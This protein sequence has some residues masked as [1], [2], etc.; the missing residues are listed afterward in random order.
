MLKTLRSSKGFTL[1]EL[2]V[3]LVIIGILAT[4]VVFMYTDPVAKVK[5]AAFN[6]RG[7]LNFAR[8]EAVARNE[9]VLVDFLFD[10]SDECQGDI[11]K[12]GVAGDSDG[13]IICVDLDE[14]A[15]DVCDAT[16]TIVRITLFREEVQ[17]YD[18]AAL[19]P[20]GPATT[21]VPPAAVA[22]VGADGVLFGADNH[23][24][25]QTN[26]TSSAGGTVV[27][28]VPK[29]NSEEI[30]GTPYAT[31]MVPSTGRVRLERWR[32]GDDW[33]RK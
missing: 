11:T 24:I 22:L 9:D 17:Y 16:D 13:Y 15:N 5:A 21:P 10:V 1:V 33:Q 29:G 14:P 30:Y 3:V 31:V 18:P 8:S 12:C 25:M 27:V 6:L 32:M 2:F 20:D 23:V 4:G 28:Y 19:P 7:D 26:G